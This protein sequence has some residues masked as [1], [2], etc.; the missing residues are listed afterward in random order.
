[1]AATAATAAKTGLYT[2]LHTRLCTCLCTCVYTCLCTCPY[3]RRCL[4]TPS[5]L[6]LH[7]KVHD[8]FAEGRG[9]FDRM[10]VGMFHRT[11]GGFFGGYLISSRKEC[12]DGVWCF[13]RGVSTANAEGSDGSEGAI[14]KVS[15][16]HAVGYLQICAGPPA[17]AVGMLR[18]VREKK[19]RARPLS[20]AGSLRHTV[21]C[22]A[23]LVECSVERSMHCRMECSIGC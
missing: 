14:G 11:F 19:I 13:F 12:R 21:K 22:G 23:C 9:S 7:I 18:D 3:T 16:R 4:Y 10:F 1:M 5:M 15:V 17:F 6:R 20:S 2:C 8:G